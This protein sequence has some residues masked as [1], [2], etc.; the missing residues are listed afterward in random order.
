[1]LKFI[2]IDRI[3][4][5]KNGEGIEITHRVL[6]YRRR[7]VM[8]KVHTLFIIAIVTILLS[9]CTST[10]NNAKQH[11]MGHSKQHAIENVDNLSDRA[12][13]KKSCSKCHDIERANYAVENMSDEQFAKLVERMSNKKDSN[14]TVEKKRKIRK[15]F[16]RKGTVIYR[17]NKKVR[18]Y[19]RPNEN[20]AVF[21]KSCSKCHDI[22][23]ANYAIEN[24]SEEQFAKLIERM[25]NKEGSNIDAE[26]KDKI[27]RAFHGQ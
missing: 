24:M 9:N 19:N 10:N 16:N 25:S 5:P 1:M 27:R 18:L 14:I 12:I 8:V 26:A 13:F 20:T 23:R 22:E 7:K 2:A 21:E 6:S 4:K 3:L 17:G 11:A 15:H